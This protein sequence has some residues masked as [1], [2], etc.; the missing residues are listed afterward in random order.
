MELINI[1]DF[2]NFLNIKEKW[3][4]LLSESTSDTLFLRHEWLCNWWSSYNNKS[5]LLV[6]LLK[7]DGRLIG[8]APL[9]LSKGKM[10]GLPVKKIEFIGNSTW[11]TNDFIITEQ[12]ERVLEEILNYLFNMKWDMA[13]LQGIPEESENLGIFKAIL[14]AKDINYLSDI[15]SSS[16]CV[17]TDMPWEEFY[18]SRSVRF[19]KATRNKLNKINKS[20]D[21][22]IKKYSTPQ[23]IKHALPIIFEIGLK[24]W[25]H[26]IKNAISSTEE[27]RAFYTELSEIMSDLGLL[28]IW[29]LRLNGAPI[30]F[31]YH[32]RY[33]NTDHGLI[34]DY[35]EDYRDLSP[36]SIL[37]FNIMQHIFQNEKCEY[38][39]GSGN[40]FYKMNWTEKAKKYQNIYFYK[41]SFYGN[42]LTFLEK[43][44]AP[45]LK[46]LRNKV[47]QASI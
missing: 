32:I 8:A 15:A 5:E 23:E 19:K 13:N 29:L 16:P 42:F 2:N 46:L 43:R 20:G 22:V 27:N 1:S 28:N 9:M 45:V 39:L 12:R 38:D 35:N 18:N 44:I 24:G 3:N 31:E 14:K 37:D 21:V 41:D 40:S 10:R 26:Q 4:K 30:A 7:N 11:T 33:K 25:K 47:K 36:G 6:L 17:T 34:A